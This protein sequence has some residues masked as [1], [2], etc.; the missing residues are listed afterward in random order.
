MQ[1]DLVLGVDTHKDVHVAAFVDAVGR[2]VDTAE[3]ASSDRGGQRMLAWL[4]RYGCLRRAGIEGTGSYGHR[5]TK[6]LRANGVETIEVNGPD[7]SARR[8]RGKSDPLDAEAAAHAVLSG[9][10]AAIPKDR[11]GPAGALRV[12]MVAR[13]S[14]VKA[15]TRP[16]TRSAFSSWSATTT[17][18][19]GSVNSRVGHSPA[20]V[21]VFVPAK[22]HDLPCAISVGVG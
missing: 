7:R 19:G 18:V 12:L 2:L 14:A 8:L 16:P 1:D 11:E 13:R 15:R 3:F 22:E 5:L 9:R 17:C 10:A 6:L 21:C 4:R 20:G